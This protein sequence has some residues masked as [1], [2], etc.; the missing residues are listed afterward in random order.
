MKDKL[1]VTGLRTILLGIVLY[2]IEL[3]FLPVFAN[4]QKILVYGQGFYTDIM[5]YTKMQ[6]Y[7]LIF[8]L[9]AIIVVI[10]IA[11][12]VKSCLSKNK[13]ASSEK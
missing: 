8:V 9:T 6:P 12:C 13:P 3:L 10:G 1:F 11:L 2:I 4:L 5:K 7:P